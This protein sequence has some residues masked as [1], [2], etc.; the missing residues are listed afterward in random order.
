MHKL[1][2]LIILKKRT[3][4]YNNITKLIKNKAKFQ[5]TVSHELYVLFCQ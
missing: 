4:S 3:A 5:E 1:N 2:I